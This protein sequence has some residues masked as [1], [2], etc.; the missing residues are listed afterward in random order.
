MARK[1]REPIIEAAFREYIND[2]FKETRKAVKDSG[3]IVPNPHFWEQGQFVGIEGYD[4]YGNIVYKETQPGTDPS[5]EYHI[6]SIA[7]HYE[8]YRPYHDRW[9]AIEKREEI[10]EQLGI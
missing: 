9:M 10:L 7:V 2:F 6:I 4:R 3:Q 1:K 8:G 5:F